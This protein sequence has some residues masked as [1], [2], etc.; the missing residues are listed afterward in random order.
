VAL[1]PD[2]VESAEP[3]PRRTPHLTGPYAVISTKADQ[4]R[5][6]FNNWGDPIFYRDARFRLWGVGVRCMVACGF[7]ARM[8]LTCEVRFLRQFGK[9]RISYHRCSSIKKTNGVKRHE[10][11]GES[12]RGIIIAGV[13]SSLSVSAL[14]APPTCKDDA[15]E[16][17]LSGA[18]LTSFMG[19]CQR[20]AKTSCEGTADERKLYGAARTSFTKKCV[21]DTVGE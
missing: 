4:Y 13:L 1:P 20:D 9:G 5:N 19:K 15:T 8:R 16:K 11:M 7:F 14:A 2:L 17:K 21:S 3:G 6:E 12:M 18:A 10:T